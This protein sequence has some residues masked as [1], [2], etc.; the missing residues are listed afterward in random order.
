MVSGVSA[1]L[2]VDP[3][4]DRKAR[5]RSWTDPMRGEYPNRVVAKMWKIRRSCEQQVRDDGR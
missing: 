5:F 3:P 1:T 4:L 2:K